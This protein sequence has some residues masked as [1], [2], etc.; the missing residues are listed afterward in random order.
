MRPISSHRDSARAITMLPVEK[1]IH[2][3][4]AR[5][6]HALAGVPP[7]ALAGALPRAFVALLLAAGIGAAAQ[8][9]GGEAW[10]HEVQQ[11]ASQTPVPLGGRVEV[12]V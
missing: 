3:V 4:S 5:R 10:V 9:A 6:T 8:T 11:L 2:P 7:H 1:S 12:E